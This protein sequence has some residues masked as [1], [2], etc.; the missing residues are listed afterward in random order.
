MTSAA[1]PA[2]QLMPRAAAQ[3]ASRNGS[4]AGSRMLCS[5]RRQG[6]RKARAISK[7][8]LSALRRPASTLVYRM[9]KTIRNEM[10]SGSADVRIQISARMMNDA[11]GTALM[12]S[13]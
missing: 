6:T 2:F 9:G 4:T 7:S 13:T 11:T 3:P 12:A 5:C 1:T 8:W 10:N